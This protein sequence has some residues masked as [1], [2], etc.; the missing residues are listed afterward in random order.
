MGDFA[1]GETLP[2][3][4]TD[5]YCGVEVAA[6]CR[7]AGYYG[8]GDAEG[9]CGAWFE[10]M[11]KGGSFLKKELKNSE[12]E[13]KRTYLENTSKRSIFLINSKNRRSRNSCKNIKKDSSCFSHASF[14]SRERERE[15]HGQQSFSLHEHLSSSSSFQIGSSDILSQPSR[16]GM[17]K[18]EFPLRDGLGSNDVTSKVLLNSFCSAQFQV[19]GMQLKREKKLRWS[20]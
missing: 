13:Y 4:E 16:S 3:C 20:D 14:F 17:F 1:P 18:V 10:V 2:D 6:G 9:E 7:G 19:I 11:R 12:W 8:E 5:G 15:N